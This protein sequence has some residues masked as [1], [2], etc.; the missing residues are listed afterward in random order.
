MTEQGLAPKPPDAS[1][2]AGQHAAIT[3]ASRGIGAAIA[4]TLA[5]LGADLTLM[6][7]NEALLADQV[8]RLQAAHG[9]RVQAVAIDVTDEA[10]VVAAFAAA[11]AAFGPVQILVNNAGIAEAAPFSKTDRALW[12]RLLDV[13]LTGPYLCIRQVL[14]PMVKAGRGRIINVASTAGHTGYAYVA[15]YC[16]AKHGLIGLTRSLAREIAR[17]GV[18]VNAVCPGYTETDIVAATVTNIVN[19]TG[20]TREQAIQELVVHNPQGRLI[21]PVEVAEAV[22]WLCLPAAASVNGQSIMIDGG[23]LM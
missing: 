22:G 4:A 9:G 2:L 17:S 6:A 8:A 15:A 7:R 10:R 18:T 12:Q 19:K 14:G 5:R 21:T 20:R 13:D 1:P 23:E 3:G 16:A 11:S